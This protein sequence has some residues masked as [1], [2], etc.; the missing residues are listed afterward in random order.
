MVYE[1]LDDE[2]FKLAGVARFGLG[3]FRVVWPWPPLA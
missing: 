3:E 1:F 2:G